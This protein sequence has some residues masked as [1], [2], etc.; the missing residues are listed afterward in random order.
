M[1]I[2]VTRS[3]KGLEGNRKINNFVSD[4]IIIMENHKL[5]IKS[6]IIELDVELTMGAPFIASVEPYTKRMNKATQK[7]GLW[8][9]IGRKRVFYP[10]SLLLRFLPRFIKNFSAEEK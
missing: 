6:Y 8:F 3:M 9:S 2:P 4:A 10:S 7:N 1:K 5:Q